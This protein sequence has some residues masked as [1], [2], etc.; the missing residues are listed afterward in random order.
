VRFCLAGRRV[1]AGLLPF[2]HF[3]TLAAMS[4]GGKVGLSDLGLRL[5]PELDF[6][7]WARLGTKL[8]RL[9]SAATWN[10]ADWVLCGVE[11]FS[12]RKGHTR[13]QQALELTGF[14]YGWLVMLASIAPR[15]PIERRR[16]ELG[17]AHHHAVKGLLEHEQEYLLDQ[18]QELRWS[19][20][21]LPTQFGRAR[22]SISDE[23][24]C[25]LERYLRRARIRSALVR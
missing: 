3:V 17:F 6:D 4:S 13:Y 12:K 19:S 11:N 8:G 9:A 10:L 23:T 5:P 15:F 20:R 2:F 22:V 18:A 25:L 21:R 1:A 16:P 24:G 14:T 7:E